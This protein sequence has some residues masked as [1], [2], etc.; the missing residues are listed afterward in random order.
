[1]EE[2]WKRNNA[3]LYEGSEDLSES[4]AKAKAAAK[5]AHAKG[6]SAEDADRHIFNAVSDA[7]KG[8]SEG[9]GGMATRAR[10]EAATDAGVAHFKKLQGKKE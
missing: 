7:Y 4:V 5:E 3:Y 6:M 2:E 9:A 8:R 1:M 10:I